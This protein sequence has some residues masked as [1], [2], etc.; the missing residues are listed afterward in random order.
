MSDLVKE[1][2]VNGDSALIYTAKAWRE[3]HN[4]RQLAH[5][6][7]S[8]ISTGAEIPMR[9]RWGDTALAIA[10]RRGL[11]PAVKTLLGCGANPNMRNCQGR[12]ILKQARECLKRAKREEKGARYPM[13][14]SW[15]ALLVDFGTKEEPSAYDE[16]MSPTASAKVH[17]APGAV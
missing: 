14:L 5:I 3:Q 1:V 16:F 11:G 17:R 15:V 6:I 7:S 4:E 10:A 9:D 8:L 2:D 13:V 12:G